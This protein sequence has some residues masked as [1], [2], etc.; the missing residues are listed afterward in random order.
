MSGYFAGIDIGSTMT[1]VAI[2]NDGLVESLISRSGPEHRKLANLVMQEALDKAGIQLDDVDY[3][4]ST[5]YGRMN[6]PFADKQITEITCHA[7]CISTYLPSVRTV[8]DIGGQDAKAI[9]IENG[10]VVDF[11]MN[12][13]CAAGSGRFIEVM[14]EVLNVKLEDMGKLSLT[15][16][17]EIAISSTCVVFAEQ[18]LTA[19]LAEG[20]SIAD[21]AA[22]IH[23]SLATRIYSMAG[24]LK[25]K[26]DIA[27]TGG[28]ARNIGLVK[29]LEDKFG[30]SVI[31]PDEPLLTGAIGAAICAREA[32]LQAKENG[33]PLKKSRG[34]L[35]EVCFY[36]EYSADGK[37]GQV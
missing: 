28:G 15:S 19:K 23:R 21:L 25:I 10:R 3:I 32:F 37:Y 29:A 24:R 20:A 16:K 14:A 36:T 30:C 11:V 8:I 4:V 5:G 31:V 17:N 26:K 34:S 13:R 35:R 9:S 1:K 7:K 12:D 33:L 6:V 18:E 22:A 2:V 27:V